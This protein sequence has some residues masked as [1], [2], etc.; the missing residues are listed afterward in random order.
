MLAQFPIISSS[1]GTGSTRVLNDWLDISNL[2]VRQR[3]SCNSWAAV[4]G[5]LSEGMGIG[6]L[7]TSWA[8]RMRQF[9]D[10]QLLSAK[11]SLR[12]LR[13]SFNCRSEDKR[14]LIVSMLDVVKEC[15]DF[16][17]TVRW[18]GGDAIDCSF[19][20]VPASKREFL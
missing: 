10:L 8:L 11:H 7:P 12:P 16:E 17:E 15:I 13:Y 18:L 9:G 2:T 19:K 20:D 5:L 3:L 14:P 6:I 1:A 4:A